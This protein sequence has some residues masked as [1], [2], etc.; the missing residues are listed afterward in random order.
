M[1][2]KTTGTL[3]FSEVNQEILQRERQQIS[4]GNSPRVRDI[5]RQSVP[6]N[7]AG[8]PGNRISFLDLYGT[9]LKTPLVRDVITTS[10]TNY[11]SKHPDAELVEF[12]CV[13]GGGAGGAAGA[14]SPIWNNGVAAAGGGGAG[15]T[16]YGRI[17]GADFAARGPWTITIG[18]GGAGVYAGKNQAFAGGGGGTTVFEGTFLTP[19]GGR[20][21]N[22]YGYGGGGGSGQENQSRGADS[23]TGVGGAGGRGDG[24]GQGYSDITGGSG[25]TAFLDSSG[26][27]YCAAGGGTISM[28]RKWTAGSP[29][30]TIYNGQSVGASFQFGAGAQTKNAVAPFSLQLY[31]ESSSPVPQMWYALSPLAYGGPAGSNGGR[32][33]NGSLG[34]GGGGG[35]GGTAGS[36]SGNGGAGFVYIIYTPAAEMLY[37]DNAQGGPTSRP[38]Y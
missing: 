10:T 19:P 37:Y 31:R 27:D 15:G 13:G 21:V 9:S 7:P 6:N 12:W 5:V 3:A 29:Y 1:A 17:S 38:P 8:Y 26:L 16:G 34:G 35:A 11:T 22:G 33:G 18:A 28:D 14:N 32:G 2:I 24:R 36:T 23:A 4:F 30:N 25:G 20:Y